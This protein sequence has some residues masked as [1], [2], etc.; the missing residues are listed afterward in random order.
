MKHGRGMLVNGDYIYEGD[1]QNDKKHGHGIYF[2][3][4]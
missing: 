3:K 4:K 1:F 2:D